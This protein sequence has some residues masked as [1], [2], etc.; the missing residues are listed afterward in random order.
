MQPSAIYAAQA[1]EVALDAIARSDGTRD[2]V[3]R[4]L[5]AADLRD[6]VIG[7]VRFDANGDVSNSLV[8]IL[9]VAPGTQVGPEAP[10]A[11]VD[12]VLRVPA[13]AVR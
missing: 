13:D 7:R 11:T 1:M 5:F 4:A 2:S 9:R 3:R 6:G 10:D 8:T 12:R